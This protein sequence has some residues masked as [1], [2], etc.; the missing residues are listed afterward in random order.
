MVAT[1]LAKLGDY[2]RN[3]TLHDGQQVMLRP[4]QPADHAALHEFFQ[5]VPA[6]DR[7]YLKEDVTDKEVLRRWARE[8]DYDRAFP[9][10]A[11]DGD[12]IVA[13]ATLHRTRAGARRHVG[14][15][16][17]VVDT[18]HRARGLGTLMLHELLNLARTGKLERVLLELVADRE[19]AAIRAAMAWGFERV[20]VL[21][22]HAK[23]LGGQ[24]HDVI[25]LEMPLEKWFEGWPF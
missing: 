14:E 7:Y 11:W 9:L 17:I 25:F 3:V 8:I 19:E 2:P 20:G 16:R 18:K 1:S 23:D 15:I 10:L 5:R 12:K 4:M 22:G 6:N 24:R 21:P 13:D